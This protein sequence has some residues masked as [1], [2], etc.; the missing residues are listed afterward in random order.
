MHLSVPLLEPIFK[1]FSL[2]CTYSFPCPLWATE[3]ACQSQLL[4]IVTLYHSFLSTHKE[5]HG[6]CEFSFTLD[7]YQILLL[8]HPF[9]SCRALRTYTVKENSILFLFVCLFNMTSFVVTIITI[10]IQF[11]SQM[12]TSFLAPGRVL[13]PISLPFH[14]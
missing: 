7:A 12:G 14:L 11:T 1:L 3:P 10:I 13:S 6:E 2:F 9:I 8:D 5:S 4:N